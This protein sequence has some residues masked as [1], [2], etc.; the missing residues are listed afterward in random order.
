M[1]N[2]Q[3]LHGDAN[4]LGDRDRTGQVGLG[5]HDGKLLAAVARHD[6]ACPHRRFGDRL[7]DLLQARVAREVTVAIVELFE[8][9]DVDH[10][11]RE[12]LRVSRAA[13][14]FVRDREVEAPPVP[15]LG[16]RIDFDQTLEIAVRVGEA[17]V[18][19]SHRNVARAGFER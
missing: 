15:D 9:V 8:V 17:C 11:D 5:E 1:R 13:P 2:L 12:R 19:Q 3:A 10:H 6:I 4:V 18:A 7:C 14:P 16:E